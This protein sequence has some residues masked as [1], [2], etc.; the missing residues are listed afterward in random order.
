MSWTIDP[1]EDEAVNT[2]LENAIRAADQAN[3]LMFCSASDQGAKQIDTYPSKAT[4]RIFTIGAAGPAGE[5]IS[6][7]GNSDLVD[8][9]F[10]GDRVELLD[11]VTTNAP[12]KEV[13]G[14][15]VATA[16]AA[17]FAALVL[18]WYVQSGLFI[19]SPFSEVVSG[20][21]SRDSNLAPGPWMTP[22][23][24]PIREEKT[25]TIGRQ[26]AGAAV[27]RARDGK[28][29]GAAGAG[30]AEEARADGRRVSAEDWDEPREQVQVSQGVECVWAG[31]GGAGEV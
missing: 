3:I 27:V 12:T 24:P 20:V 1:T 14:S 18:H 4:K 23:T 19:H 5:T 29:A 13:S 8:F 17:G 28:A 15:S 2:E 9:T 6:R 25:N 31:G 16:L 7:V 30:G 22:D 11:G 10:P 26:R 21:G